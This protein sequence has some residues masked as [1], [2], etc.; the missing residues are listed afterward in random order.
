MPG[1]MPRGVAGTDRV[2]AL[3]PSKLGGDP[4]LEVGIWLCEWLETCCKSGVTEAETVF[5][6]LPLGLSPGAERVRFGLVTV[7]LS[8][9]EVIPSGPRGA[10][11]NW[12]HSEDFSRASSVRFAK[13][14]RGE[15]CEM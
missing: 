9:R 4:R 10:L 11:V 13:W 3:R 12:G 7:R 15:V 14:V 2:V 5:P 1:G 8:D 6:S